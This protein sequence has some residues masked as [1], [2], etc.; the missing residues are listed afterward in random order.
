MGMFYEQREEVRVTNWFFFNK[1]FKSFLWKVSNWF[2]EIFK[3]GIY[4]FSDERIPL[5]LD[6]LSQLSN[7]TAEVS[8]HHCSNGELRSLLKQRV[9]HHRPSQRNHPIRKCKWWLYSFYYSIFFRC[10]MQN[11]VCKHLLNKN[12]KKI[13]CWF[14]ALELFPSWTLRDM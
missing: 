9:L 7:R 1:T 6:R 5:A 4:F 10:L 8:S 14:Q 3:A 2:V 13:G 11:Y 12:D